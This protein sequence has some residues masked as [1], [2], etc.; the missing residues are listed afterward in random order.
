[1]HDPVRYVSLAQFW[2]AHA[3]HTVFEVPKHPPLLYLPEAHEAQVLHEK[4]LRVP[5]QVPTLY[6]LLLQL[7]LLHAVQ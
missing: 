7:M 4:P 6:W 3:V 2:L 5:P 1:M